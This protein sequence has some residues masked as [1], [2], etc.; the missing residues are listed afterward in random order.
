MLVRR[1]LLLVIFFLFFFAPGLENWIKSNPSLWY[2][3]YLVWLI[4]IAVVYFGQR[5]RH[6]PDA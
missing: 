1:T 6:S 5:Q 4:V 2:R 3:P